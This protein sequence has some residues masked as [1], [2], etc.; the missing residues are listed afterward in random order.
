MAAI[1]YRRV[2]AVGGVP[3]DDAVAVSVRSWSRE[4]S[5]CGAPKHGLIRLVAHQAA[6]GWHSC[7]ARSAVAWPHRWKRER[8]AAPTLDVPEDLAAALDGTAITRAAFTM[9]RYTDQ[10]QR[11]EA[12]TTANVLTDF[13]RKALPRVGDSV[14]EQER[15]RTASC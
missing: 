2:D 14:T 4:P 5:R 9:L 15:S 7:W 1:E 8:Q 3:S 12:V 6:T 11:A 10:R 13:R